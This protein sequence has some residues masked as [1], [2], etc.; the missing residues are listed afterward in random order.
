MD[1]N[2]E[3]MIVGVSS[4]HPNYSIPVR[5]TNLCIDSLHINVSGEGMPGW[6]TLNG[7]NADQDYYLTQ[8]RS[9]FFNVAF[10]ASGLPNG[11]YSYV[12]SVNNN[13]YYAIQF[14][15][16]YFC[17]FQGACRRSQSEWSA[18]RH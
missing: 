9:L 15:Y 18:I 6:L 3:Q 13:S 7:I 4:A 12:L 11:N 8:N 17:S 10:D 14:N 1:I 2:S 16:I 5:I